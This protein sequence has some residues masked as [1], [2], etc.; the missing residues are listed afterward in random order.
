MGPVLRLYINQNWGSVRTESRS[1]APSD[2]DVLAGTDDKALF[3]LFGFQLPPST[4][5]YPIATWMGDT[6]RLFPPPAARLERSHKDDGYR[7][8][9]PEQL[10]GEGAQRFLTLTRGSTVRLLEGEQVLTI[11][12]DEQRERAGIE[13]QKAVFWLTFLVIVTLGGPLLFLLAAPDPT[14]VPRALEE[15]RVKQGLPAQPEPIDFTATDEQ[16]DGDAGPAAGSVKPR[17]HV[18]LPASVR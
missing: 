4:E 2:G 14:L 16:N 15:A 1:F 8:V 17:T 18:V 9:T 12:L 11:T 6:V 10:E 7:L 5:S 3:P 13:K